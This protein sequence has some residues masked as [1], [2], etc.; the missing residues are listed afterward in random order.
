MDGEWGSH[1]MELDKL[2]LAVTPDTSLRRASFR[3]DGPCQ[4]SPGARYCRDPVRR[5][6]PSRPASPGLP[7]AW[8]ERPSPRD[9]FH[10]P[11]PVVCPSPRSRVCPAPVRRPRPRLQ[12]SSLDSLD[13]PRSFVVEKQDAP[14]LPWGD[15]DARSGFDPI[16]SRNSDE[17]LSFRCSGVRL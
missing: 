7:E 8:G 12:D 2:P 3:L 14:L 11:P 15:V 17:Q 6:G 13:S 4:G 1:H 5:D 10:T 16:S 9:A